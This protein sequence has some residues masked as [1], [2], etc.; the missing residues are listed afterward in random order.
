VPSRL[1]GAAWSCSLC[2]LANH[3]T[4]WM[5]GS[6]WM[7]WLGLFLH[8]VG[9]RLELFLHWWS[10]GLRTKE[11]QGEELDGGQ[12]HLYIERGGRE[13]EVRSAAWGEADEERGE[14]SDGRLI[15]VRR[16]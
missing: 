13:R 11:E 1:R 5:N 3:T 12:G 10:V 9:G 2:Q 16:C 15:R 6:R 8:G 7:D 4:P 14:A